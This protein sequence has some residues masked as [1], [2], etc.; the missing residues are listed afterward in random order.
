MTE[1]VDHLLQQFC[2]CTRSLWNTYF[3]SDDVSDETLKRFEK[4]LSTPTIPPGLRC[5]RFPSMADLAGRTTR[6]SWNLQ[7]EKGRRNSS[8]C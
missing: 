2:Q 7:G 3:L 1:T 4:A 5:C 6:R 8:L